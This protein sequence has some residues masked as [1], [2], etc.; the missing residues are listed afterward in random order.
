MNDL[1]EYF[2]DDLLTIS[3]RTRSFRSSARTS[4]PSRRPTANSPLPSCGGAAGGRLRVPITDLPPGYSLTQVVCRILEHRGRKED[5]YPRIR[6]LLKDM[7]F[8]PPQ[9]LLDLP[10]SIASSCS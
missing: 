2:W 8:P 6:Q 1:P 7:A 4:S 10:G 3:K 5:I 9:C